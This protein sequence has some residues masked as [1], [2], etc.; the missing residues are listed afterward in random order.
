MSDWL[1]ILLVGIR[2]N[3]E[4]LTNVV[5]FLRSDWVR[6]RRPGFRDFSPL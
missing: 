4:G 3:T 6:A 5:V 2:H 1:T